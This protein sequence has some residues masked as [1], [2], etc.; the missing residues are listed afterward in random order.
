[1]RGDGGRRLWRVVLVACGLCMVVAVCLA[2]IAS[3]ARHAGFS[4]PIEQNVPVG[5]IL[6]GERISE[7]FSVRWAGVTSVRILF[8]TYARRNTVL[9][10]I[11]LMGAMAASG[12]WRPVASMETAGQLMKDNS[13]L[14]LHPKAGEDKY[15]RLLVTSTGRPGNAVTFWTVPRSVVE[16]TGLG[17]AVRLHQVRI[18]G[19][20]TGRYPIISVNWVVRHVAVW[21]A[22]AQLAIYVWRIW[23]A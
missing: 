9:V 14:S 21:R 1:V 10:A 17:S 13:F 7:E 19:V 12:P 22:I 15:F 18:N 2:P 16:A 4:V 23:G 6:Q 3:V 20:G 5:E 11:T 8:A